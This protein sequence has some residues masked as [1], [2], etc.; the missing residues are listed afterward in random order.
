MSCTISAIPHNGICI[1]V[2]SEC[3][4]MFMQLLLFGLLIGPPLTILFLT[5]RRMWIFAAMM[6][7]VST[8]I[9]VYLHHVLSV[10][11][12]LA[13]VAAIYVWYVW[14]MAIILAVVLRLLNRLIEPD[15]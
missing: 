3:S 12:S 11:D 15:W 8:G 7:F 9:G 2:F 14:N 13:T 1:G 4:M 6:C 10:D 5:R